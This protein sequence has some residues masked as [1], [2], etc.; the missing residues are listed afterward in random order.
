MF[1]TTFCLEGDPYI[2]WALLCCLLNVYANIYISEVRPN[3]KIFDSNTNTNGKNTKAA[4]VP[5]I[6][7]RRPVSAGKTGNRD[8]HTLDRWR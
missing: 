3:D 5:K 8:K 7:R 1:N 4:G 6:K 2:M